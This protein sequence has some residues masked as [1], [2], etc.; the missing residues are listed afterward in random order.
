MFGR[1]EVPIL[2]PRPVAMA[3]PAPSRA[4]HARRRRPAAER[5]ASDART[6]RS[7]RASD[8]R[9]VLSFGE[10]PLA[11][12]LLSEDDL[13]RPEPRYSLT[14][15]FCATCSLVQLLDVVDP[16]VLYGGDYPYYT[17]VSSGLVRHFEA[18]ARAIMARRHLGPGELHIGAQFAQVSAEFSP[19]GG[20][21]ADGHLALC[22]GRQQLGP[23][24]PG[25][26]S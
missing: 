24:C 26:E 12:V 2:A 10:T 23:D 15:A 11:E 6:C 3:R 21:A 4:P 14:L 7:C 13:A 25:R 8:L 18:S 17:S 5:P 1:L 9:V 19:G 20:R 16:V 22:L